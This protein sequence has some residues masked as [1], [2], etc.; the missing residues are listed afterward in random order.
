[1]TFGVPKNLVNWLAWR[2]RHML[3]DYFL[4]VV[5]PSQRDLLLEIGGPTASA[6]EIVSIFKQVMVINLGTDKGVLQICNYP[7]ESQIIIAD[8]CL[9][10]LKDKS[11]DFVFCNATLEHIP[12]EC[13]ETLSQEIRRVAANGFFISAPNY[14]FPFEPH[15]LVP[16]FQFV[17]E[18]IKRKLIIDY[19]LT[20]GHMNKYNYGRSIHLPKK[21]ELQ[22]LFPNAKVQGVGWGQPLMPVHWVCWEKKG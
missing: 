9:I 1:M 5:K 13:W 16:F 11:V 3:V 17:P 14:W 8:G 6:K 4:N 18:R 22:I 19:G 12:K 7:E 20:I 15:Y 10:P 2:E 21:R